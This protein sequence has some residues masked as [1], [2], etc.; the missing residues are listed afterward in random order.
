MNILTVVYGDKYID[1]FRRGCLASLTAGDNLKI[2]NKSIWHIF[3][4]EEDIGSLQSAMNEAGVKNFSLRST[5]KLRDYI[6]PAQS[7]LIQ[8][9]KDCLE[10]KVKFLMAPPDTIFGSGSLRGMLDLCKQS[11]DCVA[12]AHPRVLPAILNENLNGLTN[13]ELVS[14]AWG[15]LHRSW[16]EAEVGH[17]NQNSYIGGVAWE[18]ISE[19]QISVIHRL[20]TIYMADFIK[21]DLDYFT[22]VPGFGHYDHKWPGD[23]LVPMNRQ[24]YIRSSDEAFIVEITEAHKNVPP[25]SAGPKDGFWQA[26]AHNEANAKMPVIFK[27][28]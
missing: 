8:M 6:D 1:M 25:Q 13:S 26:N 9:I 19:K 22:V 10:R 15:Y 21:S 24:R 12:V 7:A 5:K 23:V 16:G 18:K 17:I 28:I 11:G 27:L 2:I 3:T 4:H 20:P 14:M